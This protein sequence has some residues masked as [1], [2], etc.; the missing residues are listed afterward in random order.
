MNIQAKYSKTIL[1]GL[2][3]GGMICVAASNPM[4]G[5][6]IGKECAKLI[7]DK[8]TGRASG[9]KKK[10][11]SFSDSAYS[12]YRNS[13]Y[14]LRRKGLIQQEYR[15]GQLYISLTEEGKKKAGKFQI[16]DIVL[17]ENKHWDGKWHV[18]I[19]DIENKHRLKREALRG[20]IKQWNL[21]Q[22]QKSVWV[23]PF[24]MSEEI[25]LLRDFFGLKE[26][27]LVVIRGARID[28]DTSIKKHFKLN[29]V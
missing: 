12:S 6:R 16:D 21:Y 26:V 18:L 14:Y 9:N 22:L 29:S 24:E 23:Y 11:T 25:A 27:E 2:L 7:Y 15:H 10:R 13:F 19:F 4:F 1:E 17:S 3:I 8:M 5:R 20:K 28:N